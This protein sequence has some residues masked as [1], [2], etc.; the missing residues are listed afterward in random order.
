MPSHDHPAPIRHFRGL[1]AACVLALIL[2]AGSALAMAPASTEQFVGTAHALNTDKVLYT[3]HHKATGHCQSGNWTPL[4]D[5]VIYRS[6]K[7]DEI[8][9]KTVNYRPS[10]YR[11]S[12]HMIDRQFG[13]D[14]RVTNHDDR[15]LTETLHDRSGQT[16]QFRQKVT[17]D[18]VVDA[19]FDEFIRA[20]WQALTQGQTVRFSF[21]APTRG[22]TY[23]FRVHQADAE[24]RKMINAPH[25]FVM[26]PDSMIVRWL[27]DPVLLGYNQAHRIT[28]Y[29]GLTNIAKDK[30]D[31]YRA[32]IRY[33]YTSPPCGSNGAGSHAPPG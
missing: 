17:S 15:Q 32:H 26:E 22:K 10:P 25:V 14:I 31:N 8:A 24:Q 2:P 12:F 29:L 21:F 11:P 5:Q 20:H 9:R 4:E 33:R 6:P 16:Q 28:D 23:D 18:L 27:T 13:E 30:N 19:G 3:E 7:G 1:S